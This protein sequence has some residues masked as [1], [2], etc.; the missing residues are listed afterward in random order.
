MEANF[1]AKI[2]KKALEVEI[3]ELMLLVEAF[4]GLLASLLLFKFIKVF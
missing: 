2:L 3:R 1:G 4:K